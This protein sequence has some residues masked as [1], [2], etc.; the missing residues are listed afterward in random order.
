MASGGS[1]LA[2]SANRPRDL[3]VKFRRQSREK[4]DHP[5][6]DPVA[7]RS[8]ERSQLASC[9]HLDR[10]ERKKMCVRRPPG[11]EARDRRVRH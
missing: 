8:E 2:K 1:D 11:A 4:L 5:V 3:G 6:M 9:T 7:F 10:E